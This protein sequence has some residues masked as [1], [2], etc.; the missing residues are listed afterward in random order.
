MMLVANMRIAPNKA[1]VA[2]FRGLGLTMIRI[3][4]KTKMQRVSTM[5]SDSQKNRRI[6]LTG[7]SDLFR[8][9]YAMMFALF[10]GSF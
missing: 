5:E 1:A 6:A 7:E 3:K 8:L 4:V 2:S 10:L 9:F